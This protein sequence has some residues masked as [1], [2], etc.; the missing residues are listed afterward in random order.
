MPAMQADQR[1]TRSVTVGLHSTP[2]SQNLCRSQL[3]WSSL[4]T[5]LV[6]HRQF[7][8][9]TWCFFEKPQSQF[10]CTHSKFL[11]LAEL[12]VGAFAAGRVKHR[13]LSEEPLW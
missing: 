10:E 7:S 8:S 6:R 5:V 1:G 3:F 13:A 11:G 12:F 2:N 4:S 9:Y